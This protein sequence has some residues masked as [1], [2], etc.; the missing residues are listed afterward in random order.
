VWAAAGQTKASV[1]EPASLAL[2][3]LGLGLM[4]WTARRKI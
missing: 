1:P 3:S 4:G 2:I